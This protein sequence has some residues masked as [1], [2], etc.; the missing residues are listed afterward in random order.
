MRETQACRHND[1]GWRRHVYCDLLLL[2]ETT[3]GGRLIVQGSQLISPLLGQAR[4][5]LWHTLAAADRPADRF[6]T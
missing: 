4:H 2:N 1:R 3:F 6:H 5:R